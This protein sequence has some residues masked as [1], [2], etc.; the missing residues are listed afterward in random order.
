MSPLLALPW[1]REKET[2]GRT[3]WGENWGEGR[4]PPTQGLPKGNRQEQNLLYGQ[5]LCREER[6]L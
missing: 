2:P 5:G 6:V 3:A 4:T 1:P